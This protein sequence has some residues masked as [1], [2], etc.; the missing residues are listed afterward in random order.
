MSAQQIKL[1]LKKK[2][3]I[4]FFPNSEETTSLNLFIYVYVTTTL[5]V[6]H[7][8]NFN[9]C[10]FFLKMLHIESTYSCWFDL[11]NQS[12]IYP[13]FF[14]FLTASQGKKKIFLAWDI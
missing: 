8:L 12:W 11:Y 7:P 4:L 3:Q 6:A 10:P 13:Y 14:H 2:N 1:L 5:S 9:H